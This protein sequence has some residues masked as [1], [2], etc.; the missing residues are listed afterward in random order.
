[1]AITRQDAAGQPYGGWQPQERLTREAALAAYTGGAAAAGGADGLIGRLDVG[2]RADF[3][4]VDRDPLLASVSELRA[5][6]VLETWVGG[7]KV[8]AAAG[9]GGPEAGGR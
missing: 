6:K 4:L 2:Q 7:R 9:D 8:W 3:V 1:V 5:M